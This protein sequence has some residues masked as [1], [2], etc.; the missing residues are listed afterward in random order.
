MASRRRG[1]IE[2]RAPN[3]WLVRWTLSTDPETGKQHRQSKLVRGLKR[4]AEAF[5]TDQLGDDDNGKTPVPAALRKQTLGAWLQEYWTT[6]SVELHPRTRAKYEENLKL[7]LPS[8]LMAVQLKQLEPKTLQTI[9]N[10]L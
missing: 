4:D 6:W 8:W 7:Y 2:Q 10:G 9:F 3:R 1:T 5:L